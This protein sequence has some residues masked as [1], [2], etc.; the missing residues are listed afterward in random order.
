MF[1]KC[2]GPLSFTFQRIK[3]HHQKKQPNNQAESD[4][5]F[6]IDEVVEIREKVTFSIVEVHKPESQNLEYETN[7]SRLTSH[8]WW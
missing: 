2:P 7:N 5:G 6:K 1:S 4:D 3:F 8:S